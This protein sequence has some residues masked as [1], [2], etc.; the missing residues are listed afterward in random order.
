MFINEIHNQ[1]KCI[2]LYF[3]KGRAATLLSLFYAL[4]SLAQLNSTRVERC[5]C[6]SFPLFSSSLAAAEEE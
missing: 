1:C 6:A 2:K 3:M 4:F 5:L